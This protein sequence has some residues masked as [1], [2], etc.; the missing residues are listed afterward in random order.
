VVRGTKSAP[1]QEVQESG[2]GSNFIATFE[3]FLSSDAPP[4]VVAF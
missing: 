2:S 1:V 4:S 3:H